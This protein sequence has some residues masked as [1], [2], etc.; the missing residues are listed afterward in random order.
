[1]KRRKI[2]LPFVL[3][4]LA[5]GLV[6]AGWPHNPPPDNFGMQL[7]YMQDG[8]YDPSV[9]P[10]EGDLAEWYHKTVMG[11]SDAE[12]EAQRAAAAAYF[13]EQFGETLGEP[14]AFGVDPRDEY[15][16]Y[17]ITGMRVPAEGWVVR[18]GGFRID[19]QDDG[20]G[21]ETLHGVY[22]GQEGKWVPAGSLMVF[23]EY[24][25]DVKKWSGHDDPNDIIIHYE[26]A[27]PI[28]P[29]DDGLFF[30]CRLSSN[31]FDDFGGGLAQGVS[32]SQTAP[33]GRKIANVR[34]I[35]TFPGLGFEGQE[36][37]NQ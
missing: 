12:I 26:S 20:S 7:V 8:V 10:A 33:D 4:V 25:I 17:K 28:I 27:E 34:N 37:L 19:I 21:G 9:P 16:V 2:L 36:A 24:N 35:L 18:D 15:R 30:R 13:L 1:M 22:G 14:V 29:T 6:A 32:A 23:G 11:R 3:L 5:L 31:S